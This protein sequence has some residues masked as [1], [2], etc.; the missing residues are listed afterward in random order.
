MNLHLFRE[1][2]L[3]SLSS[4]EDLETFPRLPVLAEGWS[5]LGLSSEPKS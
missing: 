1:A 3:K 2:S 4:P 5:C